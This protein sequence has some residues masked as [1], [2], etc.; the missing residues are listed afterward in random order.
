[1]IINNNY[2][3]IKN[4]GY[5]KYNLKE[6][7]VF[8]KNSNK[9][10]LQ[11]LWVTALL[12]WYK[13][14]QTQEQL[15]LPDSCSLTLWSPS[16]DFQAI[17]AKCILQ[18][19]ISGGSMIQDI[20]EVLYLRECMNYHLDINEFRQEKEYEEMLWKSSNYFNHQTS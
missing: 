2:K 19:N 20:D 5:W 15:V 3:G 8:F 1:M 18:I 9:F 12:V 17:H 13:L 6:L 10:K 14:L 7:M 4:A 11:W 16:L